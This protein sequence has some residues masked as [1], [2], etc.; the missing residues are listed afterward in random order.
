[1]TFIQQVATSFSV[2]VRPRKDWFQIVK[3]LTLASETGSAL[4][5][6]GLCLP[7][8]LLIF[9]GVSDYGVIIQ[10]S[11]Q[12]TQAASAG[13]AYG[14]IN[15]NQNDVAGMQAAAKAAAPNLTGLTTS[16]SDVYSCT[17]GG[18]AVTST[19]SCSGY[20]TPIKYV[21][22]KTTYV[23]HPLMRFTGIPITLTLTGTSSFRVRWTP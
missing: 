16:S 21:Q 10:E 6:L 4:L 8:M 19:T 20:G 13:A 7:T 5:E 12:V 22:V 15:G 1:M 3:R 23:A 18:A 9:A 11:M 14:A 2:N 17:A